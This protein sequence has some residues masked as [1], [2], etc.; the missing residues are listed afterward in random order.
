[1]VVPEKNSSPKNFNKELHLV[2]DY[3]QNIVFSGGFIIL[4]VVDGDDCP[5]YKRD[6]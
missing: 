1:M 4:V 2:A 6:K 5:D 3:I